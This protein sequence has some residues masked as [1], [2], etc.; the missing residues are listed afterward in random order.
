MFSWIARIPIRRFARK[1]YAQ[2]T[3]EVLIQACALVGE[4]ARPPEEEQ[5]Y[6]QLLGKYATVRA[7]LPTL[8]RTVTFQAT[9][10][11]RPILEAV[12]FLTLRE[13]RKNPPID[14]APR[15][16]IPR[17][18]Q[19]HVIVREGKEE[20]IDQKAYTLCVVERL[21]EALR[22]HEV[23]VAPSERWSD[24]R[25][26]LLQRASWE[27]V[28]GQVCQTLG[29]KES[30]AEALV[31]LQAELHTAYHQTR[32]NFATNTAI[33]IEQ[34]EGQDHL[35]LTPLDRLEEPKS[36]FHCATDPSDKVSKRTNWL[37]NHNYILAIWSSWYI[38]MIRGIQILAIW[39]LVPLNL[40]HPNS[41]PLCIKKW[42]IG[43]S[44]S[45]DTLNKI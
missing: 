15:K 14:E 44:P 19:R 4:L 29:R 16:V 3:Q 13:G 45:S 26:R 39:K 34:K 28:R 31:A 21:Q 33:R 10:A 20:H 1:I 32:A 8:L 2:I 38:K 27:A 42:H 37:A 5:Q 36:L 24:P 40:P 30:A 22:R 17:G 12:T 9:P 41:A 35:V 23:F 11:G 43:R 6:Q 18:W 25:A 7:F